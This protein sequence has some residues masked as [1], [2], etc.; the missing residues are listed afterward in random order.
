MRRRR[1]RGR[2]AGWGA[3]RG[4]G[5]AWSRR[6]RGR[7]RGCLTAI[8]ALSLDPHPVTGAGNNAVLAEFVRRDVK[9][10]GGLL[11][12]RGSAPA[13]RKLGEDQYHQP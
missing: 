6:V 8:A 11:D 1:R 10:G 4:A 3:G 9:A 13:S 2:D 12:E 7:R 5:N